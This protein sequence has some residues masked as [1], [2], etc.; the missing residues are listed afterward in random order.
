VSIQQTLVALRWGDTQRLRR[1][2]CTRSTS[3]KS[4][5]KRLLGRI[6]QASGRMEEKSYCRIYEQVC[7]FK[8]GE[9][10]HGKT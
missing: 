3:S 10:E 9:V 2:V 6:L 5:T 1:W 7:V 4:V 8:T